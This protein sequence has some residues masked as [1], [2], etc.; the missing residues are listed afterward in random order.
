MNWASTYRYGH[1]PECNLSTEALIEYIRNPRLRRAQ[2]RAL[3]ETLRERRQQAYAPV[4]L[5][6]AGAVRK[7]DPFAIGQTIDVLYGSKQRAVIAGLSGDYITVYV[8]GM[9]KTMTRD[10]RREDIELW[11]PKRNAAA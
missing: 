5:L 3:I 7:P 6:P 4:P 1:V 10:Y 8:P 11:N 2:G 9:D